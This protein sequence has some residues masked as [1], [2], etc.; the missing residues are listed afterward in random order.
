M[1]KAS[2]IKTRD[3]N[4]DFYKGVAIILVV[5]GHTL[6]YQ[7]YPDSFDSSWAFKTIYSF[8]MPLFIILSGAVASKWLMVYFDPMPIGRKLLIYGDRLKKSAIRLLIPFVSWTIIKYYAWGMDTGLVNYLFEVFR[9]PDNSLWFLL[10][11]FYCIAIFSTLC[12]LIGSITI[13]RRTQKIS[14]IDVNSITTKLFIVLI[15]WLLIKKFLPD[16]LGLGLAK[17]YLTYFILGSIGIKYVTRHMDVS[18]RLIPYILFLFLIPA[19]DRVKPNSYS[20]IYGAN[21]LGSAYPFIVALLGSLVILDLSNTLIKR[22]PQIFL[23]TLAYLGKMSLGIYALHTYFL[24]I[25][26]IILT[27]III[28]LGISYIILWIPGVNFLLLGEGKKFN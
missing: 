20:G 14:C 4:L 26:P 24:Q 1:P 5:I 8:H 27:P 18:L 9:R 28:S 12:L 22:V 19:W 21:F 25:T 10:A 7:L 3:L 6:Q 2:I 16:S 15:L 17:M 11:I 23:T 13:P